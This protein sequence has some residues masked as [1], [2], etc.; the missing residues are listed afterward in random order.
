MFIKNYRIID[1]RVKAKSLKS[2]LSSINGKIISC[3]VDQRRNEL[4]YQAFK[5]TLVSKKTRQSLK[6]S[7]L[8]KKEILLRKLYLKKVTLKYHLTQKIER[9]ENRISSEMGSILGFI[10]TN[11]K[12]ICC[13]TIIKCNLKT[14]HSREKIQMPMDKYS[15]YTPGKYKTI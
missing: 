1:N 2:I 12:K 8:K 6:C 9:R 4:W 15:C 10:W 11:I 14:N 5:L 13:L 3:S 7:N